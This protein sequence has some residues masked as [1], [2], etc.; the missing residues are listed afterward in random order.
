MAVR[1]AD[2]EW[3]IVQARDVTLVAPDVF[4]LRMLLRGLQ[5]TETEAVQ[6]AG[7]TVVRLD[8][9]LSRLDMDPNERGASLVF[10]APTPGMPVSDVNAAVVDA[11]FADVWARP[12]APVH[13][14]GARAAAGDVAIRWTPRTRLGGDAWQGEPASGEAVAAWRTEFLDGAGAVRR[15]IS[16]EIPEAIYPA[17]DQI[18]DFGALPAEL[19]VRV[20]QVSSRYGPGRGRDSLVRL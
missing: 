18:A 6:V 8:D 12:F 20:R 19:A 1:D 3:E 17:A 2:G 7:S 14:R 5:G 10:V 11:V 15:V 16:S 9:A 4:D 13:V